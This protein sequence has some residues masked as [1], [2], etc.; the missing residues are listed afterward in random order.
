MDN[1]DQSQRQ[2]LEFLQTKVDQYQTYPDLCGNLKSEQ[3]V[4]LAELQTI[5]NRLTD[6]TISD[7]PALYQSD[8]VGVRNEMKQFNKT[9]NGRDSK[10]LY[11]TYLKKYREAKGGSWNLI[12]LLDISDNLQQ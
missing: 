2:R 3:Y 9:Y 7:D 12:E 1:L 8:C 6:K 4:I 5:Y 10:I 11:E